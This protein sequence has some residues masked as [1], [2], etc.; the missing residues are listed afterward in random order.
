MEAVVLHPNCSSCKLNL[1]E[2]MTAIASRCSKIVTVPLLLDCCAFAGDRGLPFLELT[3]STTALESAEVNTR[4][5][6]GYYS[7]NITCQMGMILAEQHNYY[8]II[9]LLEQASRV[10]SE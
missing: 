8:S 5:Y 7:S 3:A 6:D 2:K 9:D 1:K 10:S 4:F